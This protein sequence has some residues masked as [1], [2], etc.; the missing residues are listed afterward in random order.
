[1]KREKPD[2]SIKT[3]RFDNDPLLWQ[4]AFC[5]LFDEPHEIDDEIDIETCTFSREQMIWEKRNMNNC[6]RRAITEKSYLLSAH[7]AFCRKK[8][9]LHK[10]HHKQALSSQQDLLQ[11]ICSTWVDSCKPLMNKSTYSVFTYKQKHKTAT[12]FN[13][14]HNNTMLDRH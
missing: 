3:I 4:A 6:Q 8:W 13:T 10:E 5:A 12:W 1:M 11:V 14:I 9:Y 2:L 7:K